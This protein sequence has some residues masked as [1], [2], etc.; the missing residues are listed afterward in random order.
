M[1]NRPVHTLQK[2]LHMA[3]NAVA[4]TL[5]KARSMAASP[6]TASTPVTLA[7]IATAAGYPGNKASSVRALA[8][9]NGNGARANGHGRYTLNTPAQ[10]VAL[11]TGAQVALKPTAT[12]PQVKAARSATAK[13]GWLG[14]QASASKQGAKQAKRQATDA[15]A[16]S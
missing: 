7:S 13:Q 6:A 3:S 1:G 12:K 14:K 2:G 5:S 4:A 10:W 8:R 16:N 9:A 15:T 11:L